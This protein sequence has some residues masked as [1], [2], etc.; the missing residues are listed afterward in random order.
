MSGLYV[1]SS[2]RNERYP[3]VLETLREAQIPHYDF[4]SPRPGSDGFHWT[5]VWK[6]LRRVG[7]WRTDATAAD[8]ARM[9]EHPIAIAG[10]ASDMG[11][12]SAA[13]AALLVMPCGR[14]AHL[15]LGYAIGLRK[16]AAI[17]L[18]PGPGTEPELMWS[19]AD[20]VTDDLAE[21]VDWAR[22]ALAVA[23]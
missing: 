19:M 13:Q 20:F 22:A 8:I 17:L 21:I 18:P 16:P 9:L 10:F 2:W 12:L 11:A 15:E 14:S 7:E 4:R 5:D 3:S 23:P 6:D 1:A